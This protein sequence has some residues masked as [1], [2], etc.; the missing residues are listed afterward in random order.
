MQTF[1]I[2]L[3]IFA[4]ILGGWILRRS[5][6]AGKTAASELNKVIVYLCL[7][8]L[9]FDIITNAHVDEIW[10]PG[11]IG[12]LTLATVIMFI[13]VWSVQWRYSK[14]VPQATL[15]ALNASYANT[16]YMGFPLLLSLFGTASLPLTLISTLI[17]VCCLFAVAI[18]ILE[19]G[20][21]LSSGS[22]P[23]SKRSI[24]LRI[25][26][27]PLVIAPIM[28]TLIKIA[29]LEIP[30]SFQHF[31]KL[32][33]SATAPCAL[34]TIGLFLGN[35][36]MT[37]TGLGKSTWLIIFIK[38]VLYP[39]VAWLLATSV[40]HLNQFELTCAVI[41]CALPTGTGPFMLAEH[42]NEDAEKTAKIILITTVLSIGTISLILN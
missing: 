24:V 2:I 19:I 13:G 32:L 31:F 37:L 4:L 12:C 20:N 17:T 16:G 34:I 1:L 6:I 39:C 36:R 33:G 18:I 30:A 3:P 38:L 14:S 25:F 28:A 26:K 23:V 10:K 41:L 22:G 9:L 35:H 8:A 21:S 27:N 7:P 40:F 11:F 15:D 5:K 29:P 42:Y